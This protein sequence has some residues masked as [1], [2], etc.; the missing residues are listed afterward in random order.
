MLDGFIMQQQEIY[1]KRRLPHYYQSNATIF[2][3]WRLKFSLP[4]H[5]MR[6]LQKQQENFEIKNKQLSDEYRALQ[7][8]L[9]DRKRFNLFDELIAKDTSLPWLLK[10]PQ[11]ANIVA[12]ALRFYKD[13]QYNLHC[14]C[15]MPN[16]VHMLI[17]LKESENSHNIFVSKMLYSIK[18]YTANQ[19][20]KHRGTKGAVWQRESYDH[21]VRSPEEMGRIINYILLNP[22][23]AGLVTDWM[24]WPYSWIDEMLIERSSCEDGL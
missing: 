17:T 12:D 5:I 20:N 16:H 8:Y 14:F 13:S 3:T 6:Q 19:I 10:D 9:Q 15:I 2:I 4:G 18:R 7:K 22:V 21:V 1:Y 23:K 24:D 11:Y